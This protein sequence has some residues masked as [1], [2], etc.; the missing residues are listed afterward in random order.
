MNLIQRASVL[1]FLCAATLP[2]IAQKPHTHEH[3][4]HAKMKQ[5]L[6]SKEGRAKLH[7]HLVHTLH[8]HIRQAVQKHV[9]EA[10]QTHHGNAKV[11]SAPARHAAHAKPKTLTPAAARAHH[12][13]ELKRALAEARRHLAALES[14]DRR[15]AHHGQDDV[16][17]R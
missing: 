4:L 14:L 1:A 11:H 5:A 10:L 3:E 2:L 13:H 7:E 6:H 15:E 17:H 12:V 16:H 8:D 9:H